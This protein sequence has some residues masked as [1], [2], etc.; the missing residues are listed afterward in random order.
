MQTL[1]P[2]SCTNYIKLTASVSTAN[3]N[4][5]NLYPKWPTS[6][7]IFFLK[8]RLVPKE[9]YTVIKGFYWNHISDKH[10]LPHWRWGSVIHLAS[11]WNKWGYPHSGLWQ[12]ILFL[13]FLYLIKSTNEEPPFQSQ[14]PQRTSWGIIFLEIQEGSSYF[15]QNM[16][17]VSTITPP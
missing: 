10:S 6:W 1:F 12:L 7:S 17:L 8:Q 3:P 14:K 9:N 4:T 5:E 11:Y 16:L 2:S 15:Q 13:H